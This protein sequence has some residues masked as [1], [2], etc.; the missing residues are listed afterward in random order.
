MSFASYF[1]TLN[2]YNYGTPFGS[3]PSWGYQDF[4]MP[5]F[6]F[7]GY[8]F[9]PSFSMPSIGFSGGYSFD[10]PS[11]SRSSVG[12][13]KSYSSNNNYGFGSLTSSSRSNTNNTVAASTSFQAA[14]TAHQETPASVFKERTVTPTAGCK[15]KRPNFK[16]SEAA[17]LW[18]GFSA[19]ASAFNPKTDLGP[20]FLNKVKKI[21]GEIGCEYRD[22]LSLMQIESQLNPYIPNLAG[23]GAYGLIQFQPDTLRGLGYQPED[24][25]RMTP[26]QQLDI[27]KKH[28]VS[29]KK[30]KG[31]NGKLNA[32]QLYGL[33][34]APGYVNNSYF[35]AQGSRGY[36]AN[37]NL[38]KVYGNNNGKI[39]KS[40]LA[41]CLSANRVNENIFVA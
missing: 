35:Y 4:S 7:T 32:G 37:A 26:V 11:F 20:E 8:S 34:L 33:V 28:L 25:L 41:A 39:E 9:M 24:L 31:L 19:K 2:F 27:V 23:Y 17:R 1:D 22:L 3:V 14:A 13:T 16:T 36:A 18:D 38:D 5:L 10:T 12:G 6:S 30:A 21:S 29:Q 15:Y 40:D